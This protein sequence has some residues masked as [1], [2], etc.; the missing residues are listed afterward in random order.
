MTN[1]ESL[2]RKSVLSIESFKTNFD[3]LENT[4]QISGEA[5]E[6][7]RSIYTVY[8]HDKVH[9]II[10]LVAMLE[11]IGVLTSNNINLRTPTSKIIDIAGD[12]NNNSYFQNYLSTLQDIQGGKL[13]KDAPIET[14][15]EN[16]DYIFAHYMQLKARSEMRI[17]KEQ[18]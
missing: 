1:L 4:L 2:F 9:M 17:T 16:L 3:F 12:L 14:I 11:H 6:G 18:A 5:L 15:Q 7:A 13:S 10:Y 8:E